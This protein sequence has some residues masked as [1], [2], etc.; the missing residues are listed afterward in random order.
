MTSLQRQKRFIRSSVMA[1]IHIDLCQHDNL[2]VQGT[3]WVV[4]KVE[5]PIL[6]VETNTVYEML[7]LL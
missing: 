3:R 2:S 1:S 5:V 7:R 6:Y 4:S